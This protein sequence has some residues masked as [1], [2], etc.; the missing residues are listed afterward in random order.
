M[1]GVTCARGKTGRAILN[2]LESSGLEVRGIVK[3]PDL[4]SDEQSLGTAETAIA[5]LS[6]QEGLTKAFEGL[7]QLY[8]IAPNMNV[9]ERFYG[10]N[11][12]NAAQ[13][14]GLK[15]IVFH[16]MLHTQIRALPHHWERHHV[17]AEII[18]S[19]LNFVILQCG[20]YMQN[21]LPS[22]PK[23]L[24]TRVH[25]MP[26]GVDVPMSLVDLNDVCEVAEKI[27]A[28]SDLDNGIFEIAGPPISLREKAIIL[29]QVLGV[30]IEAKKE[31]LANALGFAQSHG[32]DEYSLKTL[33]L[34]FPYYDEHGLVASPK[35]LEWLLGRPP[36]GFEEFVARVNEER[37]LHI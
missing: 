20:S 3:E 10:H 12:V 18:S 35:V 4:F 1:I 9:N 29:S 14:V 6:D 28:A 22:W 33:S 25:S 32:L 5:N 7:S 26:Y 17:E 19:G 15:K 8:Y 11:V 34:M 13:R 27:L 31:D 24:E 30:T 23:M 21:M 2:W 36:T 37:S 16:S